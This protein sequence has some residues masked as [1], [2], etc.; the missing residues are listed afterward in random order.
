MHRSRKILLIFATI[1]L[2]FIVGPLLIPV[3]PLG[4]T[5]P[6]TALADED[7]EFIS[8]GELV[9][10]LKRDGDG[11]PVVLLLHGY[12]DALYTWD[13][14]S[15]PLA[16]TAQVV[17]IDRP[18]FGLTSRPLPGEWGD[19]N[20]YG[21]DAQVELIVELLD[22]LGIPQ[23]VLVG[24]SAGGTI[25]ALTAVRHPDR[26]QA[27]VLVDAAIYTGGGAPPFVRPLLNSPQ[28]SRLGPLIV[29]AF[30]DI[31]LAEAGKAD[32][33]ENW[34]IAFWELVRSSSSA[35]FGD[36]LSGLTMPVLVLHG[37]EDKIIPLAESERLAAEIPGAELASL[38]ACGHFPQ[39]ECPQL[40]R[41]ELESFLSALPAA[42]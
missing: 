36:T 10:H 38:P 41:A 12:G 25:A 16:E 5:V 3:P 26:V 29:R 15:G 24:N 6:E 17:R 19:V 7:S 4:D 11:G 2:L 32:N 39:Q 34:D 20:P 30:G 42:E 37:V 21:T 13:P 27:L 31:G 28:M 33:I 23:A 9:V 18:G 35:Q 8:V 1:A 14:V 40:L 22:L